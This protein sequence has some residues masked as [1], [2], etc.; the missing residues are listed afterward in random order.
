M[1]HCI[2]AKPYSTAEMPKLEDCGLQKERAGAWLAA[3]YAYQ[4]YGKTLATTCNEFTAM[5]AY[6]NAL[7]ENCDRWQEQAK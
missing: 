2:M 3:T 1:V 6:A 5:R 4:V 7:L